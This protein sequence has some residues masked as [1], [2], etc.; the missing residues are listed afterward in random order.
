[1]RDKLTKE[2]TD[3]KVVKEMQTAFDTLK[4]QAAPKLILK[5]K[6]KAE[7]SD[8]VSDN[9]GPHSRQLVATYNGQ[10]PLTREDFGEFLIARYGAEQIE[11]LVN[12]R[13]IDK[14]CQAHNVSV[15]PQEI[16]TALSEDLKK[17]GAIDLKVF[18]K[19]FLGPYN[20]NLYE[21]REDVIRP[22]LQMA[23]LCR[24]RV[25]ANE[26]ELRLA[27]EAEFGEKLEGRMILWPADQTKFALMEYTQLRD[28]PNA[29]EEKA[30]HQASGTLASRGGKIGPFGKHTL[31]NQELEQEAFKLHEGEMTTLIGTPEGNAVF[32]LEKRIP[33][34]TSVTLD[35]VRE[36]LTKE[37]FERKVQMEMQTAF[38]ALRE[39]ARVKVLLKDSTKPVDLVESTKKLLPHGPD[40]APPEPTAAQH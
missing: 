19:D 15:T 3:K 39:S 33:A 35:S 31:G 22:R 12:R 11:F 21:W 16:E 17:M 24:D 10:T 29:F 9:G 38:Q 40:K 28:N 8:G 26:D 25:K 34:N 27:F 2:L 14:E 20:K 5:K 6:D 4:K 23:K 32:K 7:D 36:K 13:I 37:V 30:K 1:V 18:Q